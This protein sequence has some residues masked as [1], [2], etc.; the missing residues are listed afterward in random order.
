[1]EREFARIDGDMKAGLARVDTKIR[2]LRLELGGRLVE[3]GGRID[4]MQRTMIQLSG[5]MLAGILATL[6]TVIAT[7]L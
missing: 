3:L 2:S 7:Q 6:A 1:M 4:A 5:A